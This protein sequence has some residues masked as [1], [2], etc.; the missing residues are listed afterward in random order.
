MQKRQQGHAC[1]QNQR[2]IIH[3]SCLFRN[4]FL[5]P[6]VHPIALCSPVYSKSTID[7]FTRRADYDNVEFYSM[8]AI[9][10]LAS[11]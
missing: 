2:C 4:D 9:G 5:F 11:H 3:A 6:L 7:N 10:F 8:D 1:S